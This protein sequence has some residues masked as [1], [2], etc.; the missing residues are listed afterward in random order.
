[1]VTEIRI[2]TCRKSKAYRSV[3]GI[4]IRHSYGYPST[5]SEGRKWS[6]SLFNFCKGLLHALPICLHASFRKGLAESCGYSSSSGDVW[7]AYAIRPYHDGRKGFGELIGNPVF[8]TKG[9]RK[10]YCLSSPSGDAWRAYAI[11][12]YL[13]GRKEV[14]ESMSDPIIRAKGF[15]RLWRVSHLFNEGRAERRQAFLFYQ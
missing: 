9:R 11:R 4:V 14:G 6:V 15:V 3:R 13:D 2:S 8:P 12:P 1:M 10:V 5:L 7:R